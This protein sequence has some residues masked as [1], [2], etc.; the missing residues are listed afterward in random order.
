VTVEGESPDKKYE[1]LSAGKSGKSETGYAPPLQ[2]LRELKFFFL[3]EL[4]MI[5]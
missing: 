4:I 3:A 5:T 1:T 2:V